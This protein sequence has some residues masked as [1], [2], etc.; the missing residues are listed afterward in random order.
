MWKQDQLKGSLMNN[1]LISILIPVYN[2]EKYVEKAVLSICNQTH[3]NLQ[4]IVVDDCSTDNTYNIV[5]NI[6]KQDSRILLLKNEV[7]SK[8]VKTLNLGLQYVK[9]DYIA[10]MDGDDICSPEKLEK[11]L[12]FLIKN[13]DYSLVGSH[14]YT[15][16]ESD[17]VIGKLELPVDYLK[18]KKNI[19]YSSPVLHIWLA[20]A[21]VYHK[22]N[23]YR[24]IPGAE[25]YD[26]LLR[27]CSEGLK[28][29]NINSFEYSVRIRDGNT[30]STIGFNQ[31]LMSN[32]VLE[33][34]S[35]RQKLNYDNF[36]R[37]NVQNYI[38]NYSKFKKNF[39]KSNDYLRTAFKYKIEKR[40]IKMSFFVLLTMITS[41][42]QLQYLLKRIVF[43]I[44]S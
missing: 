19:I 20:K 5:E 35:M 11:Q 36:S 32:Y 9:G 39:D 7:N 8:I 40:F 25:D 1:I 44:K 33:L 23:G 30:T 43:K 14:V 12:D 10:R 26:F 42:F 6:A 29:T 3:H 16:N 28:F 41:R 15:I 38:E 31:R 21:D 27:M 17:K 4:V 24:E 18:I 37:E 2:V 34:Y 22:L 13:P